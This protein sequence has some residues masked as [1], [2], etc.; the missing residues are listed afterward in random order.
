MAKV[1]KEKISAEC[2]L[3][4]VYFVCLPFTVVTTP[5]GSLLKVMTFPIVALLGIRLFMGKSE[6]SLNYI[7][8]TYGLYILYTVGLIMLYNE[9]IALTTTRDMVLGLLML[10]LVS[11]PIYN[12]REKELMESA[13]IVV[14]LI[15]I[16][17]CITSGEVVSDAENRA[18][19]RILGYE[20]DQNHFCAYLIMPV[21]I[22]V[23]RITERRKFYPSYIAIIALAFYSILKA[24]SR[25][26]LLGV[27]AGLV[28]YFFIGLKSFKVKMAAAVSAVVVIPIF[29]AVV[30]PRLPED[31]RE[32]YSLSAV[33]DDGG[34][35]RFEIWQ[36]LTDYTMQRPER[37][38]RGSGIFSTYEI[39]YSA[40]FQNGVAHNTYIQI[41]SDEGI[42]GLVLFVL[43]MLLCITR[44][45]KKEPL[46]SSAM[47]ALVAF[48]MSLSFYVFKPYLNIMMMSAMSFDGELAADR[49]HREEIKND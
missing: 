22:S 32:R 41:F 7:H 27:L 14:G 48:S 44:N 13:W 3:A 26:G 38:I 40:G 31:V 47:I 42:C 45:W 2:I 29:F 12:R 34:S 33:K 20:E 15:C 39:M 36:F 25:G 8:F 43:A 18:V 11:M 17:A 16:A 37:A 19:I 6:L 1:Q 46:Y 35:G 9:E 24:G 4:C 49:Q 23:K 30:V 21:L 28:I 10:L 5:F